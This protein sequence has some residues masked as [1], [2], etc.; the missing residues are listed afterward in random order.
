MKLLQQRV[1]DAQQW[2][3]RLRARSVVNYAMNLGSKDQGIRELPNKAVRY[4]GALHLDYI[5]RRVLLIIRYSG[6][7]LI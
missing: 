1:V 2:R 5:F 6:V 3:E 7:A 4:R